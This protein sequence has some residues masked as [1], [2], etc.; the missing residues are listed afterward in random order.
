MAHNNSSANQPA[1]S[2]NV[3][4]LVLALLVINFFFS[5]YLFYKVEGMS[6]P[7]A[8]D[9]PSADQ[10]ADPAQQ[11][12]A[13]DPTDINVAEPTQDEPWRGDT[14]ARYV[15]IEYSDYE[16]PF[17]QSVH[18]TLV[19]LEEENP[20]VAWVFRDYPLGFH[21]KAEPLA[22]AAL[23]A[24]EIGGDQ[25]Y[26]TMSDAIFAAMPDL[27]VSGVAEL[28]TTNGLDGQSIQNCVDE[29]RYQEDVQADFTE[30]SNAGVQ[31]TPT[32][33]IYDT[34]TGEQYKVE[35]ALPYEQ[36][37]QTLEDFRNGNS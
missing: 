3:Y 8:A 17:C 24:Q 16:C 21:P 13:A 30:G 5:V 35:G 7:V 10:A 37:N 23:C 33:V 28:A 22:Q 32:V 18:D 15:L 27:E 9:S 14:N 19:Q 1:Q 12:Q 34:Q 31:A 6:N 26:W 2:N 29:N 4:M 11:P 25:A 36:F 20:D